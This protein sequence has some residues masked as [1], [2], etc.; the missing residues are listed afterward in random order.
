MSTKEYLK[1][2]A[3]VAAKGAIAGVGSIGG[4][5]LAFMTS[6]YFKK[7]LKAYA[8]SKKLKPKEGRKTLKRGGKV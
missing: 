2:K 8:K 5:T 1:R 7:A 6:S 4:L 3:K